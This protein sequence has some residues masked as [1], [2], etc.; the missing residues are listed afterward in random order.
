[1]FRL[2]IV[3]FLSFIITHQANADE[4]RILLSEETVPLF[5]KNNAIR[6]YDA[7]DGGGFVGHRAGR[8]VIEEENIL[9]RTLRTKGVLRLSIELPDFVTC[10]MIESELA[11][12][13]QSLSATRK[14][15]RVIKEAYSR[16]YL[17]SSLIGEV[18]LTLPVL[19]NGQNM[20]LAG[21]QRWTEE[22]P[23]TNH[24]MPQESSYSTIIHPQSATYPVG[25][26]CKP[27]T[28]G[29]E[30]QLSFGQI[31]GY[32]PDKMSNIDVI[33]RT[34]SAEQDCEEERSAL[35]ER[36]QAEDPQNWGTL[37]QVNRVLESVYRHILDNQGRPVCQEIQV[38]TVS[39]VIQRLKYMAVRSSFPVRTVDYNACLAD[40]KH[41]LK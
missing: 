12:V 34:F 13:P 9:D 26:F 28:S 15:Y 38:E 1:M 23:F 18:E 16:R 35:L 29:K 7:V 24:P 32:V 19:L 37:I 10:A 31:S 5:L 8:M 14:V 36:F 21:D 33:T 17:K 22:I 6:C 4:K 40:T 11:E 30:Y 25:L 41:P 39:A 27:H 2:S 3:M 20:V